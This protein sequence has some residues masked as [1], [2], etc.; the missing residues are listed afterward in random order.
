MLERLLIAGILLA[1]G[2]TAYRF[3]CWNQIKRLASRNTGNDRILSRLQPGIPAIVYFTTPGC[4]P[5]KTVQQPTLARLHDEFGIDHLQI[6]QID[7]TE[8]TE[9]ADQWGVMS[10]PTTFIVDQRGI[11]RMVNHGVADQNKL[12]QQLSTLQTAS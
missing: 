4:I 1:L 7:A 5:C 10:A 2:C 3:Y 6:I 11:T 12:K 8:D 9:S